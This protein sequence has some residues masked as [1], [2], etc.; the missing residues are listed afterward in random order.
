MSGTQ[1]GLSENL[2]IQD[3]ADALNISKTT[4]SRAISG[5]GRIGEETR[6]RVLD[7]IE[8]KGYRPNPMAKGLANN[9][10]YNIAWVMPGDS[11]FTELPFFQRCMS[12]VI[13]EAGNVDYDVLITMIYGQDNTGLK[14]IISNRKVDGVILGRT[15]VNDPNIAFLKKSDVPFV[16]IGSTDEPDVIQVD[17]DHVKACRE[18]TEIL[19]M[20]G[21]RSI[22]LIGGDEAHVVNRS[23]RAGFESAIENMKN[24]NISVK[25]S[26]HMNIDNDSMTAR[27]VD[28]A[29]H[30]GV[31]C[32]ICMDDLLCAYALDKLHRDN[33]EIPEDVRV[34]SFY[35]SELLHNNVPAVTA[36]QY[37]PLELGRTA[38][39]KLFSLING[40]EVNTLT[41]LPY[42]VLLK[43]STQ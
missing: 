29:L 24:M 17:N 40:E 36:L 7:Y 20:K 37:D 21:I 35:N 30:D 23:R 33:I 14:R 6:N 27:L 4:V 2:T 3:I 5:K 43:G 31:K 42:E 12:G 38:A 13:E 34:A 15:L 19:I 26:I 28:D 11:S 8:R 22:M 25:S 1:T 10:T 16:V 9:R 39:G 41:N 32:I 18:L